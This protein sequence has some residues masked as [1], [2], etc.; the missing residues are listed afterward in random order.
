[1][2]DEGLS[3]IPNLQIARLKFLCTMPEYDL[4][5]KYQAKKQLILDIEEAS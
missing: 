1:M 2:E 4:E 3:K 5:L